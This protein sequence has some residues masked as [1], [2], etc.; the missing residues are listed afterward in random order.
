MAPFTAVKRAQPPAAQEGPGFALWQLGFR[1]FYLLASAFAALSIGLWAMQFAGWLPGAYLQGPLW[2]AHEMLFGFALAVI[3]GFL[4][5]AGRNWSG[6]PTPVGL[7]LAALA[8]LWVAGRVL[9]LTPFAWTAAVV[10]AAFPLACAVALAI[11]LVTARNR[12][13][14][15]FI[16]LLL[17]LSGA[18]FAFHLSAL[19]VVQTPTWI[20]IQLALDVLLFTMAVMGGRVIPMF[21]NNGISGANATRHPLIEKVAL[22]SLIA[23][24]ISDAMG[25]PSLVVAAIAVPAALVHVVRWL[26]WQPW[27][28]LNN[29]LVLVLHLAYAWIPVHLALRVLALHGWVSPS[30]ATHALTVGAAGGLII[31][32]MVRTARGHTARILRADQVD[33]ACFVLVLLAA[34][35]RIFVPLVAPSQTLAAV[36]VSGAFWTLGFGLY[37]L[38]YWAVLTRP[39][40]D[41]KPG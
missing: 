17:V 5:T 7:P 30:L 8:A 9:V 16:G 34:L 15:F 12:R 32:M 38:R 13:N 25:L 36:L 22:G 1:P 31:G 23:L 4:F 2:H 27:K 14:Y 11:P 40:L 20:G 21:T 6:Q 26:L 24:P 39:R 28:T 29:T 3:V 35:V 10:N 41:G 19:G 37:A 18:A 33:T